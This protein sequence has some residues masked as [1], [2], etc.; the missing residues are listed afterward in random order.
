MPGGS[1]AAGAVARRPVEA[2]RGGVGRRIEGLL[3]RRGED[4][5]LGVGVV[6][7]PARAED[8]LGDRQAVRLLHPA[9]VVGG[10]RPPEIGERDRKP[11]DG[12]FHDRVSSILDC[13][14][15]LEA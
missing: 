6:P 1:Q 13:E 12:G 4:W 2:D 8:R 10:G 15:R 11:P 5:L 14:L 3:Q 7:R 9:P